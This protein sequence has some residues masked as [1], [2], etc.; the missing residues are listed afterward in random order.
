L[1]RRIGFDRVRS[2]SVG[3]ATF[4]SAARH[5][6]R[7]ALQQLL[8]Q[9]LRLELQHAPRIPCGQAGQNAPRNRYAP[10]YPRTALA[11]ARPL[12]ER[13]AYRLVRMAQRIRH[14]Q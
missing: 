1:R 14:R 6:L 7:P 5:L 8:L 13:T 12:Q 11:P 2:I 9:V 4:S 3:G 10:V